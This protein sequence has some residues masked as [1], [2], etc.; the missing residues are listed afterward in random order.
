MDLNLLMSH[1]PA[2]AAGNADASTQ[3]STAIHMSAEAAVVR[4]EAHERWLK[5]KADKGQQRRAAAT[6]L[7]YKHLS[8]SASR[9]GRVAKKATAASIPSFRCIT[10]R[11]CGKE[12]KL[13]EALATLT[14]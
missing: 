4:K 2:C 7:N 11:F 14:L 3:H 12:V 6:R 5:Y 1:Q 13:A 10:S 8:G 9:A